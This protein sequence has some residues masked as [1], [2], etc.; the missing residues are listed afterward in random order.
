[1]KK[2]ENHLLLAM[3]AK[4]KKIKLVLGTGRV[5]YHDTQNN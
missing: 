3:I 4:T 1:M 2:Q 5:T